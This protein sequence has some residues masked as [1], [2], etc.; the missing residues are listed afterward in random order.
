[1]HDVQ[2]LELR[3][4]AAIITG[5]ASGI[6][7]AL[8]FE[9]V[10]RGMGVGI[11]DSDVSALAAT[12]AALK[13]RDAQVLARVVDVRDA[14]ALESFAAECF[15]TFSSVAAVFAN[16]G[17]IRYGETSRPNLTDWNLVID[18]NLRGVVHCLA[19][20]VGR[21]LE[22]GEPAQFVITGSQA[23]FIIAPEIAAYAA[24]K[25]ALW[26][27]AEVLQMELMQTDSPVRASLVAPPRIATGILKTTLERVR[28]RE[29][30]AAAQAFFAS[31]MTPE[32]VATLILDKARSREFLILP[33]DDF[34]PWFAARVK[35][36]CP[37]PM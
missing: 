32:S 12:A 28:A 19:S 18:V 2:P 31:L 1:M 29:G 9:A 7:R 6:G 34:K 20:A 21:M 10:S 36:L 37:T 16:A 13:E 23:S 30:E 5:A 35:S 11:A 22:R 25:H 27:I 4:R 15:A 14:N 33:A 26:A 3:G 24:T 17:V 8:A